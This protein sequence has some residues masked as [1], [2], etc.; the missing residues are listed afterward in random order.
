MTLQY[1]TT[2][3]Q[4]VLCQWVLCEQEGSQ[5]YLSTIPYTPLITHATHRTMKN[6]DSEILVAKQI[7]SKKNFGGHES[8]LWGHWY[9]CF[10]FWWRLLWVS[11]PEWAALFALS[12]SIYG[13]HFLKFRFYSFLDNKI[14]IAL[15][16]LLI[17]NRFKIM[18]FIL[19][20]LA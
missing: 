19:M 6:Y 4:W 16:E 5:R 8:F 3:V 14:S 12:R 1:M 15:N 7:F 18:L 11:K 20:T 13:I 2:E 10:N 17:V 9:P